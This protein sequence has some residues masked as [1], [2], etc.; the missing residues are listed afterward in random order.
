MKNA[1]KI[2]F[3]TNMI[4]FILRKVFMGFK[5]R[6]NIIISI[7]VVLFIVIAILA[8]LFDGGPPGKVARS[9]NPG[10][11]YIIKTPTPGQ[12]TAS[13]TSPSASNSDDGPKETPLPVS[14]E[15]IKVHFIDCR[16]KADAIFIESGGETMLIDAGEN[17]NGNQIVNY[18]KALGYDT[19]DILVGTHP[20]KDHIGGLDKVIENLTVKKFFMPDIKEDSKQYEQVI[21]A[22][23]KK[24]LMIS[25]PFVGQK[26]MVGEAECTVLAPVKRTYSDVNSHSIVIRMRY[27]EK[28]FL[29][30]G[31][32]L[33]DAEQDIINS[34]NIISSDV[35]K[36]SHHGGNDSSSIDFLSKVNP[37]YAVV[38]CKE[39]DGS[40]RPNQGVLT[41]LEV[42]GAKVYR[43]DTDGT[44]VFS[45]DGKNI[46]VNTIAS[47]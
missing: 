10:S 30:T 34:G 23:N 25:V 3:T 44:I 6:N 7:M 45:T 1:Y 31:D 38:F 29:F 43:T 21:K 33:S 4:I 22:A 28:S 2:M 32:I 47:D 19:I 5:Y 24:S 14:G 8:G 37:S 42:L 26:F 13:G 27:G 41:R 20:D 15:E 36:V 11:S 46:T 16:Q 40:G 9:K 12:S 18:I 35:L 39:G 17:N